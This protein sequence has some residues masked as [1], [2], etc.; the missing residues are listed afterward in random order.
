[1][2]GVGVQNHNYTYAINPVYQDCEGCLLL[3]VEWDLDKRRVAAF[4]SSLN[5]F[6]AFELSNNFSLSFGLDLIY[7]RL[8]YSTRIVQT[9][10]YSSLLE[11]N[12]KVVNIRR[13]DIDF[14]IPVHFGRT[15]NKSEFFIGPSSGIHLYENY[16]DYA[17]NYNFILDKSAQNFLPT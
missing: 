15:I 12:L 8:N 10:L 3:L 5:Y 2:G 9:N 16:N 14:S 17:N 6:H 11:N 1:M 4:T 7:T 13:H